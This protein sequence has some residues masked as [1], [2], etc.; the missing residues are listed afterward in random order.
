VARELELA[1]WRLERRE[2]TVARNWWLSPW[3]A[4]R[5]ST[6]MRNTSYSNVVRHLGTWHAV[7][8]RPTPTI[9]SESPVN[10]ADTV[11]RVVQW[12]KFILNAIFLIPSYYL[13]FTEH[14]SQHIADHGA[15]SPAAR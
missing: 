9:L 6:D 10:Q 3:R 7:D 15:R 1:R 4:H 2:S 5:R 14:E 11:P 12:P 13:Y 8:R